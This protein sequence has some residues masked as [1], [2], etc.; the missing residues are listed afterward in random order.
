MNSSRTIEFWVFC[1][2]TYSYLSVMRVERLAAVLGV[3]VLW[4]PFDL[5]PI[6]QSLGMPQGPFRANPP[7]L[8]YM[9]RDVERRAQRHGLPFAGNP[10]YPLERPEL[11]ATRTAIYAAAHGWCGEFTR[12][13]Y[14][15]AFAEGQMLGDEATVTTAIRGLGL[16]AK[17]VLDAARSDAITRKL[18]ESTE[19]AQQR[20][21]FGSPSFV[22]GREL[23]WGDDRLEDALDWATGQQPVA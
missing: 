2:S 22:I 7:K 21:M 23:F 3:E 6:S 17:V 9:W 4:R 10:P 15:S 11:L 18:S 16:D 1:G 12:A 5:R 19:E 8:A 13:V 20:G 14:R